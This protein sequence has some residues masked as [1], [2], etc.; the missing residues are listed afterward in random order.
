MHKIEFTEGQIKL[1]KKM[2]E[3][4]GLSITAIANKFHVS[5]AWLSFRMSEWGIP[6]RRRWAKKW[7]L[8]RG[9]CGKTYPATKEYFYHK[10]DY[11]CKS[12]AKKKSTQISREKNYGV[13]PAMYDIMLEKQGGVC[14]ICGNLPGKRALAVDHDHRTGEV[15]GLLC[16]ECNNGLGHFKD[17]PEFLK[18]AIDYLSL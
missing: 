18:K 3:Q 6:K 17:N 12:C 2:Y 1:V 14:P 4:E 10:K 13:T 8:C 9:P 11:L 7:R 15:R 16:K 5:Y